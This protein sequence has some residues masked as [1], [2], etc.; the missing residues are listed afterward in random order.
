MQA[1][2]EHA[3]FATISHPSTH[4]W[5]LGSVTAA[6]AAAGGCHMADSTTAMAQMAARVEILSMEDVVATPPPEAIDDRSSLPFKKDGLMELNYSKV[7]VTIYMNRLLVMWD[8][9][10]MGRLCYL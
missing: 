6:A 7:L 10:W 1:V 8:A 4:P 2:P 9:Q 5:H 3:A